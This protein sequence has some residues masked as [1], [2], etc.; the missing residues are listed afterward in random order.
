MYNRIPKTT[1]IFCWDVEFN[2]PD[3]VI[4]IWS[5]LFHVVYAWITLIYWHFNNSV[6]WTYMDH[7]QNVFIG[8]YVLILERF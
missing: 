2:L 6:F 5:E 7:C 8:L 4:I 1:Y 3:M